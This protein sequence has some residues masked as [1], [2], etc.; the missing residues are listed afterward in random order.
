MEGMPAW[1]GPFPWLRFESVPEDETCRCQGGD[2]LCPRTTGDG[3][4]GTCSGHSA[5]GYLAARARVRTRGLPKQ[6][7]SYGVLRGFYHTRRAVGFLLS[8][9]WLGRRQRPARSWMSPVARR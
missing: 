2:A 7:F 6:G 5:V 9:R 1:D 8:A 4:V 3:S